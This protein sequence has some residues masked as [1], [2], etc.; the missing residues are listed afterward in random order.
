[1]PV[2]SLGKI[3]EFGKEGHLINPCQVVWSA[4]VS[5]WKIDDIIGQ[6]KLKY[7]L[8]KHNLNNISTVVELWLFRGVAELKKLSQPEFTDYSDS[9]GI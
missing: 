9:F 4:V 3:V 6:Y 7:L 5:C 1:M 8:R 2:P